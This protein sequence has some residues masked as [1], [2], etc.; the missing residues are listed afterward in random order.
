MATMTEAQ[1]HAFLADL[2]VGVLGV[3]D[4]D[5]VRGPLTIPIWYQYA[6]D[7]G[8]S[9]ITSPTSRKGRAIEGAG[10][11]SLAA[12]Q[13]SLPYMYVAVDGPLVETIP[14][15]LD[16]HLRPMAVR[17]LGDE[18]GNAYA[19]GWAASPS[20]DVVYRMEPE[21]WFSFDFSEQISSTG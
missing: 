17:Y 12:Q 6:P 21:R 16:A 1:R 15:D 5:P 14:C 19:E 18:L 10:R 9:I 13:E 20:T 8:V 3:T 4:P 7:V 11:F 2:H